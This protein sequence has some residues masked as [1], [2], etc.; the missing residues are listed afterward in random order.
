MSRLFAS[1][2]LV[3][4]CAIGAAS[5]EPAAVAE[6]AGEDENAF[7]LLDAM[8]QIEISYRSIEPNLRD[9]TVLEQT[10]RD[11]AAL[12]AWSDDTTFEDFVN[13]D[14]FYSEPAD[15]YALQAAMK[16]GA[17]RVLDGANAE[18]LDEVR[19]GFIDMKQTCTRCHKRYSP[20]H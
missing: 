7:T 12:V 4:G 9:A 2:L 11:A 19:L 6:E 3:L 15:F 13:G 17:Q 5:C 1:L 16:A 8:L 10:A 18:D 20:S 14:R